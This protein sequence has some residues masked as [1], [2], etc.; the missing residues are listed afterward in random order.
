V[1]CHCSDGWDRTAQCCA[2]AQML[3]DPHFRTI[4]GLRD[5]I[6]KDFQYF[7]HKFRS[8]GGTGDREKEWS[9]IFIQVRSM[10][11]RIVSYCVMLEANAHNT[12]S[13][14]TKPDP[15]IPTPSPPL[16]RQVP[17]EFE[18]T[19]ALLLL[20]MRASTSVV[21]ADFTFDSLHERKAFAQMRSD[22]LEVR[23]CT[24]SSSPGLTTPYHSPPP[25]NTHHRSQ[26]CACTRLG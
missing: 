6:S 10:L 14:N 8:R 23:T 21:T 18:Y 11:R 15:A 24:S 17:T 2:L 13:S 7:G 22:Q 16:W 20:L 25:F 19:D 5:V 9:P 3:L 1:L 4:A 26:G 12:R